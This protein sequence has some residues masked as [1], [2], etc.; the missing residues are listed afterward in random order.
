MLK[1]FLSVFILA[2]VWVA[3]W[4]LEWP[5]W[6]PITVTTVVVLGLVAWIII[7]RIRA[8]RASR[9][10]EKALKAQAE[11]EAKSARPD[12]KEDIAALQGEFE[13]A[14][15]SLKA[16]RLGSRGAA[17]ALYALPW[18]VIVGRPGAGKS[19]ALRKSGLSFPFKSARGDVS[20]KGVGGTRNCEWWMTRE[21]VIL[22]TAGRYTSEDG[23]RDEWLAFLDLLKRFRARRPINGIMATVSAVDLVSGTPQDAVVLARE[24]RGRIDELQDRLGVVAPVYVIVTK[25]DLLPGFREMFSDLTDEERRQI[26]GFTLPARGQSNLPGQCTKYFD[27]L[28]SGLEQRTLRRLIEEPRLEKRDQIYAFPQH[29]ASLREALIRF[30]AEISVEDAFHETPLVRG[31]YWSSGTQEGKPRDRIMSTV[32]SAFGFRPAVEEFAV[33]KLEAK[34]YFLGDLFARVIFPDHH[35]AGR[36]KERTRRQKRWVNAFGAVGLLIAMCLVWLPLMSFKENRDLIA[37][38]ELGVAYVDQH[39]AED[40]VDAI[41]LERLDTLRNLLV[42]L[43]EYR[44]SGEPWSMTMGMYQGDVIYPHL[45]DVYAATVRNELLLPFIERDLAALEKFNSLYTVSG[46]APSDEDY[47]EYFNKLRLYLLVTGPAASGEPGLVEE[48]RVW[49]T[50]YLADRWT[51]PLRDSGETATVTAMEEIADAYIG[52]LAEQPILAFERDTTLVE[53]VQRILNRSDRTKAVTRALVDSVQGR[54]YKLTDMVGA[55]SI[56]NGELRIR[57]A[58]TRP[59]YE[60]QVKPKLEAGLED[61]LKA[62]WVIGRLDDT[63]QELRDEEVV[64]IQSEYF[65][66]YILEWKTFIDAIETDTPEDYIGAMNLLTELTRNDPY[67]QL[68]TYISYHTQLVELNEDGS[69]ADDTNSRLATEAT[70]LAG[71]RARQKLRVGRVVNPR[72]TRIAAEGAAKKLIEG[73]DAAASLVLTDL[74]VTY[75]FQG[76]SEFGARRAKPAPDSGGPPP[77]PEAVPIDDYQAQ[78]AILRTALQRRMD[79][80]AEKEALAKDAKTAQSAVK[81][82]LQRSEK[83]GWAPTLERILWPPIDLIWKLTEKGVAGDVATKWCSDVVSPFENRLANHYPFKRSG[84]DV[85][86]ADFEAYFHPEKGAVW[87]FYDAVLK[88]AVVLRG[89]EYVLAERGSRTLGRFKPNVARYLNAAQEV[90]TASFTRELELGVDFDVLIEGAPAVKE[91]ILTVDGQ[92]IKHRNGP[93]EWKTI[94]WPG[95]N[96]PGAKLQARSVGVD[97]GLEREGEWAL[98]RLIEEGVVKVSP[99]RRTFIVQWDFND[100]GA[101]LIQ[102]RFRSKSGDSPFFGPRGTRDFMQVYRTKRLRVPQSI[103][104]EGPGCGG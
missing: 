94:T 102:I 95:E 80:P 5:L 3:W 15:A 35:L 13:Q 21:A 2:M 20:V 27:E 28:V 45:R 40:T 56:R 85:P 18:Y 84:S 71:V 78:L 22:D 52:I 72:L 32:A 43:A 62:Q 23:D 70:R 88:T 24:L 14:I 50:K 33:T 51:K 77:P 100:D 54:A 87:Q 49:V 82:L 68:F 92:E 30:V 76:L 41:K 104:A 7:K 8:R 59:G 86:L 63:A 67:K 53:R 16:S 55:Q 83:T 65:R 91:V 48:E 98:F 19:T 12:R 6:I 42:V 25:C 17:Q 93:E 46:E 89:D 47:D 39:V 44:E 61:F 37:E 57:P 10:I 97:A 38:G 36:S 31:L 90:S 101:G 74:D 81:S 58:F 73:G 64:A 75:I 29:F 99:D 1:Y 4:F 26:W 103:M 69:V 60:Q 66:Q 96:N 11:R 34:S 9:E 79:D